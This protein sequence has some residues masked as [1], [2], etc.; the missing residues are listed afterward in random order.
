MSA[1]LIGVLAAMVALLAAGLATGTR[2][3]YLL[4]FILLLMVAY[5]L[6]SVLWTLFTARISMKGVRPRV[7]R[8]EKLMT[9]LTLEHLSL[10]HI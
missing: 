5:S 3:Y 10:I 6:A 4:F 1:R 8:G 2:I 7:E 9:I